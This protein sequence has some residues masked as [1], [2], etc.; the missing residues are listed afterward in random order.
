MKFH[1]ALAKD[2]S[3]DYGYSQVEPSLVIMVQTHH[4]PK[5]WT[6]FPKLEGVAFIGTYVQW[7]SLATGTSGDM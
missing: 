7:L 4:G 1:I 6:K 3:V 5:A 2:L